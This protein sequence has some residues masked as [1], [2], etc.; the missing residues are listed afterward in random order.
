MHPSIP[1]NQELSSLFVKFAG[2]VKI[3]IDTLLTDIQQAVSN[4]SRNAQLVA[5]T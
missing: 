1:Y 4:A 5:L 3:A 2:S